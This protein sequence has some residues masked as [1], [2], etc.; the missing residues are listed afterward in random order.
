MRKVSDL[1]GSSRPLPAAAA[2][3]A[4][5]PSSSAFSGA[6]LPSSARTRSS[7]PA[8]APA[9]NSDTDGWCVVSS[10]GAK[11]WLQVVL[12]TVTS[13]VMR[14]PAWAGQ[15]A[16]V[17]SVAAASEARGNDQDTGDSCAGG[18]TP[19]V[20]RAAPRRSSPNDHGGVTSCRRRPW[21]G[22]GIEDPPVSPPPGR[23]CR[24]TARQARAPAGSWTRYR[25][26]R[27]SS[28]W[29]CS[30]ACRRTCRGGRPHPATGI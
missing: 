22:C 26:W 11:R 14:S 28:L 24:P 16:A 8:G 15:A 19:G 9:W 12:V 30:S 23:R 18:W 10:S 2:F 6:T 27:R 1:Q 3:T 20:H 7:A 17:S 4:L 29:A 25:P 5:R 13:S 21:P